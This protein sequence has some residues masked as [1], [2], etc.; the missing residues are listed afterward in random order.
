MTDTITHNRPGWQEV[1]AE[2]DFSQIKL[3]SL[4][5]CA[6]CAAKMGAQTL[7][8]LLLPLK[9]YDNPN[10]LVGLKASDDAA[11]YQLQ[12]DLAIVQTVDFFPPVVNDP[13]N[14]GA[15]A[16]ANAMSDVY[17]MGGEVIMGINVV[18][19]PEDLPPRLLSRI[20]Q[21]GADKMAE[22]GAVVAGG[23]TVID[24]EPKYGISVTGTIHPNEIFTK[25][26]AQVGDQLYLTKPLG[27]GVI[28]TAHKREVVDAAHLQT[29]VTSMTT[30]NRA[31]AQALKKVGAKY[32]HACT[33]ITGFG[34]LGH[35]S[36]MASQSEGVDLLLHS[37]KLP[38]LPGAYNYAKAGCIPGG[39]GRNRQ[40]LQDEAQ[41]RV[42][43]L[44]E[45]DPVIEDL[46][47]DPETSGGLFF[48][49]S[50][51]QSASVE[52]AFAEAGVTLWQVGEA[53]AG[54]GL[55]LV[56]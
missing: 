34:I 53:Q 28:T 33:D 32:I 27:I 19:F 7:K 10:L 25:G 1:E 31:A 48:A 9:Q 40:F 21:G 2:D 55:V 44:H 56:D 47:F 46:L 50:A 3:T 14:Y 24:N 36:E 15:I 12:P 51:D 16:A 8:Q 54:N 26:G 17:A 35:S 22:V 30:L 13:Y 20:L 29:A 38:W 52:Q 11:V 6:G 43:F 18:A 37:A 5:A 45:I 42:T 39:A 4:A 49:V 41:P 23:H